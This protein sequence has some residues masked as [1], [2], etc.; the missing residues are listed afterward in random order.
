MRTQQTRSRGKDRAVTLARTAVAP[1]PGVKT[2]VRKVVTRPKTVLIGSAL[3]AAFLAGRA[4][5]RRRPG[6]LI[7]MSGGA[8]PV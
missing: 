3:L 5:R 8:A 4:S 6:H 7:P 2:R 1:K